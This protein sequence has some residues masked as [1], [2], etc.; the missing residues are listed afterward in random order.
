MLENAVGGIAAL[1]I[2]AYLIWSLLDPER[3]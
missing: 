1:G 3:F 2:L